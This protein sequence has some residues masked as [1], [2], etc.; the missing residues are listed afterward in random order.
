LLFFCNQGI[1]PIFRGWFTI[2]LISTVPVSII[3]EA[4]GGAS[5]SDLAVMKVAKL[6]QLLRL[7]RLTKVF[8]TKHQV[9]LF[10]GFKL[11]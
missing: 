11:N 9:I 1:Q 5:S 10:S 3:W 4:I 6:F 7:I 8:R 2:D